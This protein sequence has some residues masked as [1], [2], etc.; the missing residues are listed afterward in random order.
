M[1]LDLVYRLLV[2]APDLHLANVT[3][4]GKQVV[5]AACCQGYCIHNLIVVT[6]TA[7]GQTNLKVKSS[8]LS[9]GQDS[10]EPIEGLDRGELVEHDRA[11]G[12][13]QHAVVPELF[14]VDGP[15]V[16]SPN[17]QG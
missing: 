6:V 1:Y 5:P 12:S 3:A 16:D 13:F 11:V 9:I 15:E 8:E 14:A 7:G 17:S 2:L 4:R 10:V